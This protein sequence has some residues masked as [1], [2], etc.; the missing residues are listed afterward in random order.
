MDWDETKG[1]QT[2]QASGPNHDEQSGL[3]LY[4]KRELS[5]PGGVYERL[6][7]FTLEELA[8]YNGRQ[9]R[10]AYVAVNGIV[11]D[12]TGFSTWGQG[13]HYDMVA[14]TDVSE[15]SLRCHNHAILERLNIVGRLVR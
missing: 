10:P 8:Q 6:P 2:G 5:E 1:R 3:E 11:Y 15:V 4:G 13:F 9:G 14:G 7:I 12:V